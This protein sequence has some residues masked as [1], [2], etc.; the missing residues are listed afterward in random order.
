MKIVILGSNGQLG[1]ILTNFLNKKKKYSIYPFSKK[2]FNL[3]NIKKLEKYIININPEIIINCVAFTNV[4]EAESKK[5]HSYNLNSNFLNSL[6]K[7]CKIN[8]C[9]LFHFS[10]DYVF[11]GKKG[12]YKEKDLTKP[13][14]YYGFTKRL[15]EK[16]II[17]N[18]NKYIIIRT[19]W[20][21]SNNN[22]SFLKKI[23]NKIKK[24]IN[25]QVVNDQLGFPTSAYDLSK[26][27]IKII[28][29]YNHNKNI[30]FGIYHY[31]NF[32][33][34]PISWYEFATKIGFYL[35]K[36]KNLNYKISSVDSN[37]YKVRAKRPNNS[38]LN[39][40]K[41]CNTFS[42]DKKKW[43]LELK[44]IILNKYNI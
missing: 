31:S 16:F 1:K 39:I 40:D 2:N 23:S 3:L 5:K 41:I 19:S 33:N 34:K 20:L 13:I 32:G 9:M 10:T 38:S 24:N 6:S 17:K 25:I 28:D 22:K 8:Q 7:L 29:I 12:N 14:N 26:V 43:Y 42:I 15:G 30:K 21:Y 11:D 35:K 36:Y 4:D 44:K 37:F 18:L 27:I